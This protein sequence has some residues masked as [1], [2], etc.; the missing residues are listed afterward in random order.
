[1]EIPL[2]TMNTKIGDEVKLK[3]E[4]RAEIEDYVEEGQVISLKDSYL[5]IKVISMN[6]N[7][8]PAKVTVR[9]G[10]SH[11]KEHCINIHVER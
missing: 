10:Y 1:M 3:F 5:K 7:G 6:G 8:I 9:E 2:T 11:K 4:F